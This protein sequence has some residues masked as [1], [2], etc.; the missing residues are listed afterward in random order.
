MTKFHDMFGRRIRVGQEIL[1]P[2]S[3]H[4][5][6]HGEVIALEPTAVVIQRIA[7]SDNRWTKGTNQPRG[8]RL[9]NE[10]LKPYRLHETYA[11]YV[12]PSGA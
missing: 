6:M 5:M 4:V 2:R 8:A 10:N 7:T 9:M 3:N 12:L 11:C 1:Y